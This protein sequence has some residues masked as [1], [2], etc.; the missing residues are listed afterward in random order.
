MPRAVQGC[1]IFGACRHIALSGGLRPH[2]PMSKRRCF[3]AVVHRA[4][5]V[6]TRAGADRR[7]LVADDAFHE[8]G[9]S[10]HDLGR[11]RKI[12][13]RIS[14]KVRRRIIGCHDL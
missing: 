10:V 2:H 4:A 6:V 14:R 5:V 1:A 12:R 3:V 13:V 9:D 8:P 7:C 11:N